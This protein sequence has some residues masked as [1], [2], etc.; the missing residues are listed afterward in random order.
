MR[1]KIEAPSRLKVKRKIRKWETSFIRDRWGN[2]IPCFWNEMAK[3][4]IL[5]LEKTKTL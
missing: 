1:N 5:K 3:E 2:L 4:E